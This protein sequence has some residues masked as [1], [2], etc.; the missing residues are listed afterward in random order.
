MKIRTLA[1]LSL[2]VVIVAL[3]ALAAYGYH[4]WRDLDDR[5][6]SI[7]NLNTLHQQSRQMTSAIDYTTLV[8]TESTVIDAMARDARRLADRIGDIDHRKA[9]LAATHLDE[10]A[11]MG[12]FMLES[13][14]LSVPEENRQRQDDPLLML[15]RQMRIHHAGVD[16]ALSVLVQEHNDALLERLYETMHTLIVA[17]I[18]F[19]LLVALTAIIIHR[20]LVHP[21]GAINAGLEA[22]GRGQLDARID[23]DRN[24]EIGELT[25]SF[26]RMAAQ[27]QEFE[28]QLAESQSR[29][30]Q[31]AENI[32][33]IFWLS[34]PDMS[35]IHYTSPAFERI[36][37]YPVEDLLANPE[38][39]FDAIHEQDRDR[40]RRE[41]QEAA[42][43]EHQTD[44]RIIRADG[45]LRW[46]HD[47]SVPVRDE[48]GR[49][50]HTVGVARDITERKL[51][52]LQL[53]ERIKEL[54]CLY[55]VLE[56][57]TESDLSVDEVAARVAELLPGSLRHEDL[58]VACIIVGSDNEHRSPGWQEPVETMES[59]ITVDGQT[60]GL[61]RIGYTAKPERAEGGEG[62]FL[63]EERNLID[64][65]AL[66]MG[67][68]IKHR[69]LSETLAQAERLKAVGELT[70]GIAHDFNN[71]LTVIIG[72]AEL[73]REELTDDHRRLAE[74]AE[75]IGNAGEH[76]AQL[77]Q[78]LLAFARRQ[79]LEPRR[80][81]INEL[82]RGMDTLL[83]RTLGTDIE[84]HLETGEGALPALADT[85]QLESA[86]LN[87]CLNARDAMADG[88]RLTL[89]T[90][91]VY[92]DPEYAAAFEEVTP[93]DYV[94]LGISDTGT[95]MSE[96]TLERVFEP[97]YTTKDSG[98]GLGLSMVYGLIKQLKG[99]IRIYSE[100]EQ[101]TT[102]RV[103]LPVAG[104]SDQ[105]ERITTRSSEQVTGDETILLV[106]DNELVRDYARTQLRNLGYTILEASNGPQALEI[107]RSRDDIDL[108]FT[109]VIMAGGMSGNQLADKAL[110][111][112]PELKVL[113]TSGY[114]ENANVHHGRLDPGIELLPKPYYR[115]DLQHRIR[116]ILDQ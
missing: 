76:G 64:G 73:L 48:N 59:T 2:G 72:N 69:R 9:R 108:L 97:F 16:E 54:G 40:V 5:L 56:L 86:I 78:Q 111:I 3:T 93:G 100:L 35:R 21:I 115:R 27:R 34:E 82:L 37:G 25:R 85:G 43:S 74:L 18:V 87:L 38:L 96:D 23:L 66:H 49:I 79:K 24:D 14:P 107:I 50:Q 45:S 98:T 114:T 101:G 68:M 102:V 112:R 36:W 28:Q 104:K 44:Y 31:I 20:R 52:R 60:V 75:M 103:Y 4:T 62:P 95:G 109:D 33:E 81:D 90:D 113:Y 105:A 61:V 17:T 26:N 46:I 6:H 1:L 51:S 70:G 42:K 58:A 19:A 53:N 29:F 99:H 55:R 7:S 11:Q 77:T 71:L 57:T 41:L 116:R 83:R 65:I 91:Y 8:R 80:I 67:R 13:A 63:P 30:L 92:L 89:E 10:I 39:W 47:R 88:G 22:I 94:M 12:E 84:L 106:E 32:D 15:S 110:E